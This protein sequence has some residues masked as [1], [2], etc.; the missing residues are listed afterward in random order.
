MKIAFE[1]WLEF[2]LFCFSL[3]I[4]S[5]Q[6]EQQIFSNIILPIRLCDWDENH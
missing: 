5:P 6:I 2:Y 3:V 1:K 4:T